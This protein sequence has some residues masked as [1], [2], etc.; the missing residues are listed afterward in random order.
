MRIPGCEVSVVR[1]RLED[2]RFP[3]WIAPG[4][5]LAASLHLAEQIPKK[6][7]ALLLK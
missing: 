3:F 6:D 2:C 5:F 4:E 1:S 7:W